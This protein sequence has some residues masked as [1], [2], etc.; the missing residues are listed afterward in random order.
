MQRLTRLETALGAGAL[1]MALVGGAYLSTALVHAQGFGGF[2]GGQGRAG[3]G[4]GMG[5]GVGPGGPG[6]GPGRGGPMGDRGGP[7]GG[8]M[9]NRLDLTDAQKER[10][11][12][13]LDAHRNTQEAIGTRMR[14]ARLAL[15]EAVVTDVINE[16]VV[17]A[18]AADLAVVEADAAVERARLYS[19]VYQV[20]T[21]DQK[22]KLKNLQAEMK[23]RQQE[24]ESRQA[25]RP[26]RR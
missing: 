8:L 9:L 21:S 23:E 22:S 13:I 2:G 11:G 18:R 17:R 26:N 12:S 5:R 16:S 24:R 14:E 3:G 25:G 10:V 6:G 1:V 19:D 4:P 15:D 20:L 7:L